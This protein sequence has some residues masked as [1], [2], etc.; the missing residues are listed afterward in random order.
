M[1]N[2]TFLENKPEFKIFAS[3]CIEAEQTFEKSPNACVKLVRTAAEACTKW[4]YDNDKKFSK[5]LNKTDGDNFFALI[6]NT[7]FEKAVGQNLLSKIHY[8]RKCGNSSIHNEKDFNYEEGVQCLSNLFDF[9]QWIDKNYGKNYK[10]RTFDAEEI[11]VSESFWKSAAKL[12]GAAGLG[13][14]AT[15]FLTKK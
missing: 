8:C 14:L 15:F 6:S 12:I 11:P 10:P 1:A 3:D 7:I 2:F 9:V 4:L 5:N 13:A